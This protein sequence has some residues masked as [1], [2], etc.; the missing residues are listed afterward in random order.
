MLMLSEAKLTV[1]A[2]GTVRVEGKLAPYWSRISG[3]VREHGISELT[4]RLRDGQLVFPKSTPPRI[5]AKL[6]TFLSVE[7]PVR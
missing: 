6:K 3:F 2:G 5:R 1:G 4:V 7:C